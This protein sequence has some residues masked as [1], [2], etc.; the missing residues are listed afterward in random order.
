MSYNRGDAGRRRNTERITH[1]ATSKVIYF[2][3]FVLPRLVFWYTV[4]FIAAATWHLITLTVTNAGLRRQTKD[5]Q[6]VAS[7]PPIADD[8][9]QFFAEKRR[10]RSSAMKEW[11]HEWAQLSDAGPKQSVEG[12]VL[13]PEQRPAKKEP[14]N[15]Q[16][17]SGD[18]YRAEHARRALQLRFHDDVVKLHAARIAQMQEKARPEKQMEVQPALDTGTGHRTVAQH[19][20]AG[21]N[22]S[23]PTDPEQLLANDPR[24][25]WAWAEYRER[26]PALPV[27]GEDARQVL[28]AIP[29]GDHVEIFGAVTVTEDYPERSN[30][31]LPR[32][33]RFAARTFQ[34]W[35]LPSSGPQPE[36]I[37]ASSTHWYSSESTSMVDRVAESHFTLPDH[38]HFYAYADQKS[39]KW[40]HDGVGRSILRL[41]D[42]PLAPAPPEVGTIRRGPTSESA[43]P[44][45]LVGDWRTAEDL[46]LWHMSGP[47]GFFG[48]QLTGGVSDRGVDVEHPEAVAQVKM[49]ANPVGSPLI[50]QLR[51]AQPHLTNHLFY[52]TSGYTRAASAEASESGV[53]LFTLDGDATVRP[54]GA[55]AARLIL[56]GHMRHGGDDALVAGYIKSVT[57]RVRK[58]QANYGSMNTDAWLAVYEAFEDERH[59]LQRAENYL[60]GAVD[61]IKRHPRIG[62][63]THKAVLSHFR[64]AD[65]GAAYFCHVLGLPYPGDKPL[66]RAYRR[67]TAADFY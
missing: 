23:A 11:D 10:R 49:Q 30:N 37:P 14:P 63:D 44:I 55:H 8:T 31:V 3:F 45:R 13:G 6:A 15:E 17:S 39:Y 58:A 54:N 1:G 38:R 19:L 40:F 27:S 34:C 2:L 35:I 65:L 47:L 57:E 29:S 62:A 48:S 53:A 12:T 4:K 36:T 50:R 51:G 52:S 32:E 28:S 24:T 46:A 64:N 26:R 7:S 67:S 22:N 41:P 61:A 16:T 43:S 33:A 9:E 66:T 59:Q 5:T 18:D 20:P 25:M 21:R 56:D 42:N 60:K